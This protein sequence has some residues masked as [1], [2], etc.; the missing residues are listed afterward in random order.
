MKIASSSLILL[1][2][3]YLEESIYLLSIT[4][5]RN[6]LIPPSLNSKDLEKVLGPLSVHL[7]KLKMHFVCLKISPVFWHY[8]YHTITRLGTLLRHLPSSHIQDIHIRGTQHHTL[9]TGQGRAG[10]GWLVFGFMTLNPVPAVNRVPA[11]GHPTCR[12]WTTYP[13]ISITIIPLSADAKMT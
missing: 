8:H 3:Y 13:D 12:D 7:C 1:N 9:Q 4:F 6:S 2:R 11:P 5:L 10:P